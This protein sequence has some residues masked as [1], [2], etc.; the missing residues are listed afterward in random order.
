M[1]RQIVL[2]STLCSKQNLDHGEVARN[3]GSG[4]LNEVHHVE[5]LLKVG[6]EFVPVDVFD[7]PL[8]DRDYIEG[9][10]ILSVEGKTILGLQ[11]WDL[12]DQ[13]WA[14]LLN[15]LAALRHAPK[16]ECYF[17][18]QP[19]RLLLERNGDDMICIT[20]GESSHRV[21]IHTFTQ[22]VRDGATRFSDSLRRLD[23]E[24]AD[25]IEQ[26]LDQFEAS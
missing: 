23:S 21:D 19:L 4:Q 13:L 10:I 22:A 9:A 5:T 24:L 3:P 7:G 26:S 16:H 14:Y 11:H 1:V 18:D 25:A 6:G 2:V 8:P 12:V 15:G 17:P 20:I